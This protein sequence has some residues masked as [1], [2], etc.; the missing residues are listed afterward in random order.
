MNGNNG[1]GKSLTI[2]EIVTR[3]ARLSPFEDL[4][5]RTLSAFTGIWEKLLY[6]S[7][8]RSSQGKYHHWGHSRVHGEDRSQAA[9]RQIHSDLYVEL[10]RTP[11]SELKTMLESDEKRSVVS[12]TRRITEA[13]KKMVPE[14]LEGGSRRHFNSIVLAFRLIN[15]EK[16]VSSQSTA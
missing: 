3:G 8:L 6:V 1:N 5:L 10:L 4:K 12:I 2:T 13:G 9:L 11:M 15:A 7:E 16:Q 14:K